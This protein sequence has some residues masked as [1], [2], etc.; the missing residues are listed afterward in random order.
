LPFAPP[1][2]VA[3]RQRLEEGQ[4]EL[5]AKVTAAAAPAEAERAEL[6]EK[7]AALQVR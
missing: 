4:A 3:R 5:A 2:T 7:R 1:Q 6:D